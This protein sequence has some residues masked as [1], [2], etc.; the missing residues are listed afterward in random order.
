MGQE[1]LTTGNCRMRDVGS[2]SSI[3]TAAQSYQFLRIYTFSWSCRLTPNPKVTSW[4]VDVVSPHADLADSTPLVHHTYLILYMVFLVLHTCQR[5]MWIVAGRASHGA[6]SCIA[7][8]SPCTSHT[9][10]PPP[11]TKHKL[12]RQVLLKRAYLFASGLH[13]KLSRR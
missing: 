5:F 11:S 3:N 9:I 7:L 8:L 1:L 10:S 12:G 2:V 4:H 6:A 13:A